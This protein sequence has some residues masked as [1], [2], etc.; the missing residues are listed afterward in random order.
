MRFEHIISTM[1]R[2]NAD[3][4]LPERVKHDV[5]VV[6]QCDTEKED[7]FTVD[8]NRV[9]MFS[10]TERGLSNSRNALLAH[11]EGD[12]CILGDDDLV[13][14]DGYD[15]II[16][17]AYKDYPQA[18]IICFRFALDE[19]LTPRPHFAEARNVGMFQISKIA[20][21][22]VTFK[23]ESVESANLQFCTLL[24]VGARFGSSEENA[25]LADA[26]RAGLNIQYVPQTICYLQETPEERV[27]WQNGFDKDY[28][29]KRGAC[30]HRIYKGAFLPFAVAFLLLK[31]RNL[32]R[33][34]PIFSAFRWMLMGRKEFKRLSKG[35]TK[36]F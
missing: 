7:T 29:V 9:R 20:S 5:L 31:K 8:G 14:V 25:F 32:F 13:Y 1:H 21:V 30:F 27:K 17:Q 19:K 6:N 18:D 22:E 11:A 12:I 26:L 2:E 24:G 33:D 23:R 3:F 10:N 4:L 35:E 36:C 16:E 28:F 34:V 15:A